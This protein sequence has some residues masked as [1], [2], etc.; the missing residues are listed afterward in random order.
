MILISILQNDINITSGQISEYM[1]TPYKNLWIAT[2]LLVVLMSTD[3]SV[4][5]RSQMS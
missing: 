4:T 3:Y 2:H 1:V 5:N